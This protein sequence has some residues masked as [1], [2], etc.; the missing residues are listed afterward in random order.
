MSRYGVGALS[1]SGS[2]FVFDSSTGSEREPSGFMVVVVTDDGSMEELV[3]SR[4]TSWRS[5]AMS[6]R[7][8]PVG[9]AREG[10]EKLG[11]LSVAV[12]LDSA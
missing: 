10:W 1:S 2:V 4:P 6:R 7:V 5:A 8:L 11:L 9:G 3:P 12:V